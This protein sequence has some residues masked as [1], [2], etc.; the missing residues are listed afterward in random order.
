MGMQAVIL[1][2]PSSSALTPVNYARIVK[3]LCVGGS[4]QLVQQLWLKIPMSDSGWEMWDKFRHLVGHHYLLS[5]ALVL[6]S[7]SSASSSSSHFSEEELLKRWRGE[8]VKAVIVPTRVFLENKSGRPVLPKRHATAL[9]SL[10]RFRMHVIFAGRSRYGNGLAFY[11][12]YVQHL[13][14]QARLEEEEEGGGAEYAGYRDTL[15]APLQPLKENLESQTYEVFESDPIKYVRYEAATR[16]ALQTVKS[17]PVVIAVVGAGR[18]PLVS[19]ALRAAASEDVAVRIYA[20]EKNENAVIT[21]QNRVYS[22]EAGGWEHVTVVPGD[23]RAWQPPEQADVL[24]SELLG[25]W[26]DNELSPECLDGAQAC[27]KRD[28]GI[29]IPCD[30][31]SFLAPLSTNKLWMC[32]KDMLEGRGLESPFV[33]KL[34]ACH[35]LADAQPLFRFNHPNYYPSQSNRRFG[36]LSFPPASLSATLHGFAGYFESTLFADETLSIAPHSHTPG[37]VSWFPLFLPLLAP[38][39]INRGDVVTVS[40]WRC[41]GRD[42]VWYEWCLTSPVCTPIQNS[43]GEAYNVGL[44]V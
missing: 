11:R 42:K 21:L 44:A 37:L 25:S 22:R 3:Q 33:V 10:L 38:L 7:S 9:E 8:P 39:R 14:A 31:T 32:A 6:P 35:R 16:K 29:C 41:V 18:G 24:I 43:G 17:R 4:A 12:D 19:A 15:Q 5:I 23:A 26:G 13:K 2:P 20:V 1:P 40:V 36:S 27:L 34:H 28:G 30:Y